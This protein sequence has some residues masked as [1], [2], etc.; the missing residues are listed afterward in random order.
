VTQLNPIKPE[1]PHN[2]GQMPIARMTTAPAKRLPSGNA[3]KLMRPHLEAQM[4]IAQ[5]KP[6]NAVTTHVVIRTGQFVPMWIAI[7][8]HAPSKLLI[9][10][11]R[12]VARTQHFLTDSQ[13]HRVEWSRIAPP[14]TMQVN[15]TLMRIVAPM[16]LS[17][18]AGQIRRCLTAS[19]VPRAA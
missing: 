3:V 2:G 1:M 18:D 13:A 14:M 9:G 19:Q 7:S 10:T 8:P 17:R 6:A 12:N 11:G 4:W 5:A 16:N 15:G